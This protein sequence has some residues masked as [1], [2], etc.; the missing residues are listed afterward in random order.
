MLKGHVA[1]QEDVSTLNDRALDDLLL[2]A[3]NERRLETLGT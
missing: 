3:A 1:L 2:L